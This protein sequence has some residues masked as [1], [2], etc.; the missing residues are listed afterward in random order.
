MAHAGAWITD[1][2]RMRAPP[3][4]LRTTPPPREHVDHVVRQRQPRR[5]SQQLAGQRF[6]ED[7]QKRNN[8]ENDADHARYQ[9]GSSLAH[10]E[11]AEHCDPYQPVD[12]ILDH[13]D[14]QDGRATNLESVAVERTSSRATPRYAIPKTSAYNRTIPYRG[15]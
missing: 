5:K 3:Q 15:R 11:G 9:F 7:S 12:G 2:D 14:L 1:P 13:G 10:E 6:D 4:S 8:S